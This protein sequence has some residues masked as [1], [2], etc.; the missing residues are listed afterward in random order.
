MPITIIEVAKAAN[1]SVST[2]SLAIRDNAGPVATKT[3][4]HIRRVAKKLGYRPNLRGRALRQGI[5]HV[6]AIGVPDRVRKIYHDPYFSE[7][8]EGAIRATDTQEFSLTFPMIHFDTVDDE[9]GPLD[10]QRIDGLAILA[11]ALDDPVMEKL[12]NLSLP[13]VLIGRRHDYPEI[14]WVD[15]D[16]YQVTKKMIKLMIERGIRRIAF[17]KSTNNYQCSL[18]RM[19]GY[20]D[21]LKE[22]GIEPK[23]EDI[24]EV[25]ISV[26][27]GFRAVKE[28]LKQ[29][30]LPGGI[31]CCHSMIAEGAFWAL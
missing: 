4:E 18:D 2:A 13:L 5:N 19:H 9:N 7:L 21:M 1:V 14:P 12:S 20:Y 16:N 23:Q 31:F 28:I 30:E 10:K 3:R 15:T 17:I 26:P 24:Y 25:E 27:G 29:K 11:P 8:I 22:S 6:I